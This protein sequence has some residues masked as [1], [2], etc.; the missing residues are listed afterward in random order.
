[1]ISECVPSQTVTKTK[2]VTRR[3]QLKG[4]ERRLLLSLIT[5]FLLDSN[6]LSGD[7]TTAS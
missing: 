6:I 2:V 1:M 3:V 7:T 5:S 4:L